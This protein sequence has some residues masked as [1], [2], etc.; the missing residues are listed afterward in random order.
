MLIQKKTKKNNHQ[1]A[2]CKCQSSERCQTLDKSCTSCV[3]VLQH[4]GE[5]RIPAG[6]LLYSHTPLIAQRFV[7]PFKDLLLFSGVSAVPQHGRRRGEKL[8]V[9][10]MKR[11]HLIWRP[12][13]RKSEY[14]YTVDA[15][16]SCPRHWV[17]ACVWVKRIPS[18]RCVNDSRGYVRSH[19][20]AE[21]DSLTGDQVN[22]VWH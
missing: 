22:R 4:T 12:I 16:T 7:S 17:S 15:Y 18:G 10:V 14:E 20:G 19:S 9:N 8:T 2:W 3:G 6:F 1:L 5:N 11:P 21:V 13:Q